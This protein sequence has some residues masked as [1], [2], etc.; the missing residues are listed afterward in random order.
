MTVSRPNIY[1]I[2]NFSAQTGRGDWYGFCFNMKNDASLPIVLM[3]HDSDH[4]LVLADH[5]EDFI[6][7]K[8][9]MDSF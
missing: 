8:M 4:V 6:F 5:L 2:I 1:L 3:S 7:Y 9:L